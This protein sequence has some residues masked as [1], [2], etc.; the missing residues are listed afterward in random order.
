MFER[1]L[2]F[3][4]LVILIGFAFASNRYYQSLEADQQVITDSQ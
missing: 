4:A 1:A 3:S 2:I